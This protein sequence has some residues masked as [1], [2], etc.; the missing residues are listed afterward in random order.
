M[1]ALHHC[2]APLLFLGSGYRSNCG[3]SLHVF[4]TCYSSNGICTVTVTHN[5]ESA[6]GLV[7]AYFNKRKGKYNLRE[8]N[9]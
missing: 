8:P 7:E 5:N 4:E 2:C 9:P 3:P 1:G 6:V